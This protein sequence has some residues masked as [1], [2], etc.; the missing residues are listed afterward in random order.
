MLR[1]GDSRPVLGQNITISIVFL[2]THAGVPLTT[3]PDPLEARATVDWLVVPWQE[4]YHRLRATVGTNRWVHLPLRSRRPVSP[5]A[6][7]A[8]SGATA[9][10]AFGAA[11]RFVHQ[12]P[13][14]VKLLLARSEDEFTRTLPA[15][16]N[17]VR[18]DHENLRAFAGC[19]GRRQAG[20]AA[21]YPSIRIFDAGPVVL[22]SN[23]GNPRE[24]TRSIVSAQSS[25]VAVVPFREKGAVQ[26]SDKLTPWSRSRDSAALLICCCA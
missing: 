14:G 1:R 3:D 8:G 19:L 25:P 16:E 21:K 22:D 26:C 15:R 24:Y 9:G 7:I 13:T 23:K 5:I 12:S 2:T 20:P 11:A 4:G 17:F 10:P 6:A 18:V